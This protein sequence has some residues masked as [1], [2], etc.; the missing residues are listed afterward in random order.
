MTENCSNSENRVRKEGPA[1]MFDPKRPFKAGVS[2]NRCYT[3][4]GLK[5]H[6]KRGAVHALGS[7]YWYRT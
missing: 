4:W 7:I 2:F 1:S 3:T 6:E 5:E